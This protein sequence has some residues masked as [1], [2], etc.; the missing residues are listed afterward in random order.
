[1]ESSLKINLDECRLEIREYLEKLE[2][3]RRS[4]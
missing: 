3:L 4:L 1:M 2:I